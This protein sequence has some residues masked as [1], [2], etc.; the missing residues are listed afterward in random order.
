MHIQGEKMKDGWTGEKIEQF[1]R[2]SRWTNFHERI[3]GEIEGY[4]DGSAVLDVGCGI[5]I[6]AKLIA[7]SGKRV[8]AI[9]TDENAIAYIKDKMRGEKM[10]GSLEAICG[11]W[12]NMTDAKADTLLL[13]FFASPDMPNIRELF[14]LAKKRVIIIT[15]TFSELRIM[16]AH[17]KEMH[18]NIRAYESDWVKFFAARHIDY[19]AKRASYDFGQ[20][21]TSRQ[22]ARDF[23]S[24]Y[25]EPKKVRGRMEDLIPTGR[26]DYPYYLKKE[27]SVTIFMLSHL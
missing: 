2:A 12:Q 16:N 4:I 5:G 27:K 11:D 23:L 21:F 20:P 13:S 24:R 18:R 6:L 17:W 7:E 14:S 10:S 8:T 9:D 1:E 22:E 15:H 3:F 26:S 19:A 25:F